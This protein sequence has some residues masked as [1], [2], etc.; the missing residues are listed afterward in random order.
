VENVGM[1]RSNLLLTPVMTT[2]TTSTPHP[3]NPHMPSALR[4]PHQQPVDWG[5]LEFHTAICHQCCW[6]LWRVSSLH[7]RASL[8]CRVKCQMF[9]KNIYK[10]R[11]MSRV[12]SSNRRRRA[13]TRGSAATV[14]TLL[15]RCTA[16][17]HF[18]ARRSR[19]CWFSLMAMCLYCCIIVFL[20]L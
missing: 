7:A 19:W 3:Q 2:T 13:A 8:W 10:R 18:L 4:R 5:R 20:K 12:L 16:V 15:P 6:T 14:L 11:R 9:K 1:M 17:A